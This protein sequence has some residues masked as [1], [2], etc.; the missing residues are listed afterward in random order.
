MAKKNITSITP[1]DFHRIPKLSPTRF[2][3]TSNYE[4]DFGLDGYSE[5]PYG[6]SLTVP[7]Q[8]YTVQE[9]LHRHISG[10]LPDI[11]HDIYYDI[12]DPN[13]PD[14]FDQ[15]SPL[16]NPAFDL[17]DYDTLRSSLASRKNSR[18]DS[19]QTQRSQVGSIEDGTDARPVE[20]GQRPEGSDTP[21]G[22]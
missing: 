1:E 8:S 17:A 4:F 5:H 9:L 11:S 20:T 22:A 2:N 21:S 7:N 18:S 6:D 12:E 3:T 10:S 14:A 19:S 16:D 13:S 15:I